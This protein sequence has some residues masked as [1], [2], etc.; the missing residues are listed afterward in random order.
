MLLTKEKKKPLKEGKK[1]EG[2]LTERGC[3]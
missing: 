1:G 3:C 2:Y